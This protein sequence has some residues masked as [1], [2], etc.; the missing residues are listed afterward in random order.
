MKNE[1]RKTQSTSY[2]AHQHAANQQLLPTS[3]VAQGE[4]RV[5]RQ[6]YAQAPVARVSRMRHV[7]A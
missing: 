3:A 2:V 1:K 5:R 7:P 4:A 6:V